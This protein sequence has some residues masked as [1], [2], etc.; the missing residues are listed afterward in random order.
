MNGCC[1]AY[2]DY[3]APHTPG[4]MN[5]VEPEE[6][7]GLGQF[8]ELPDSGR[9][10]EPQFTPRSRSLTH[11]EWPATPP[12]NDLPVL[13]NGMLM[14]LIGQLK[15]E[16]DDNWITSLANFQRHLSGPTLGWLVAV[17]HARSDVPDR[18][19]WKFFCGCCWRTIK[20]Q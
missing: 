11:G 13:K 14:D 8:D 16:V 2:A 20:S 17:T 6:F 10:Y 7:Y 12:P 9:R 15:W 4:C 3:G 19:R 18:D 1:V 5:Y